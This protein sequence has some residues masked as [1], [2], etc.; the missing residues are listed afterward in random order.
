MLKEKMKIQSFNGITAY[1][2]TP[3]GR[4]CF[5]FF[6]T[7]CESVMLLVLLKPDLTLCVIAENSGGALEHPVLA[8]ESRVKAPRTSSAPSTQPCLDACSASE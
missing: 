3:F 5:M 8:N 6:F 1:V 7:C 2:D 4:L